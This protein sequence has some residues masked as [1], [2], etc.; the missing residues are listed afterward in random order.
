[1]VLLNRRLRVLDVRDR[2]LDEHRAKLETD[3]PD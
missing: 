3:Y 1:V 2:W